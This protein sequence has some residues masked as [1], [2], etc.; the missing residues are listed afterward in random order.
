MLKADMILMLH[1]KVHQMLYVDAFWHKLLLFPKL[2]LEICQTLEGRIIDHN[3]NSMND[4]NKTIF[5]PCNKIIL[6]IFVRPCNWN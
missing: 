4:R 2:Y 5:H 6:T 1:I 3:P